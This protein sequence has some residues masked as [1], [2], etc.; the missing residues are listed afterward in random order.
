[1]TI[2][3]YPNS[4]CVALLLAMFACPAAFAQ[5]PKLI[6]RNATIMTMA[7]GQHTP[8]VGYISVGADGTILSVTPGEPPAGSGAVTMVDAHGD[9]MIPG[10]ISSHSHIWQA[11]WRGLAQDKTT[12]PWARD[13]YTGH[14][15]R[16]TPEDMFL[17]T[18]YGSLD[19]LQHG[20]TTAYDFAKGGPAGSAG[21]VADE[22][23]KAQFRAKMDSGIR[24]E[25]GYTPGGGG[26]G[27]G[28]GGLNTAPAV[29]GAPPAPPPTPITFD[30]ARA[31]LKA[32][33]D[34]ASVQQPASHCLCV[35]LG[36]ATAGGQPYGAAA[37]M[38]EFHLG[39]EV[40]YLEAPDN[41]G[42]QQAAF[43]AMVASG[44]L[45]PTLFFGHFIHTD[46]YILQQTAKAGAGM[47][48]QPL[49][50][51]R[52]ASGVADIPKY[53]KMGVRVGMG[54]DGEASADLADPFENM[55]T[56]LYA[57][58]D[59]YEDAGIMSPYQ[60]LWLHTM[61]SAD[62]MGIKDKVGSLE[63][64]KFADFL[65]VNPARLGVALEDPYANLVFVTSQNDIDS[66]YVGGDLKVDHS[67]LLGQ[68]FAKVQAETDRRVAAI[69]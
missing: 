68:D 15:I 63:P 49:S 59:K 14:A 33:L 23:Q 13:L 53:L 42:Q 40:H 10:F 2:R 22:Y 58:R 28:G 57:V 36:G 19:H 45:G 17:F 66:I 21:E 55:R 30:Q 4:L 50:N 27:G 20:I 54:V 31:R 43:G 16:A 7:A 11:A 44:I 34:W 24:F 6:V 18:L 64:G 52:L 39:N 1:M 35:M 41:E 38:K 67:K 29:A 60:V 46:D 5:S 56:G 26:G 69:K 47:S 48:W 37:L 51:G 65:L 25:H 9:Y 32:F 12:P 8:I 61:G 62:V 3:R